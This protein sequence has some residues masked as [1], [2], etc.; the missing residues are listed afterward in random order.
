MTEVL[1]IAEHRREA[2]DDLALECRR[3]RT[4]VEGVRVGVDLHR[5]DV[6]RHG[7]RVRRLEHLPCVP[8]VEEGVVV[9]EAPEQLAQDVSR[10]LVGEV[11]RVVGLGLAIAGGPVLDAADGQLELI[12]EPHGRADTVTSGPPDACSTCGCGVPIQ[13]QA[14]SACRSLRQRTR[15]PTR[16][17]P[18]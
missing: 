12:D 9:M 10:P 8:G 14:P 16:G 5:R 17:R 1:R 2:A 6:G 18:R 7:H 13:L 15:T 3:R 11:E 4:A